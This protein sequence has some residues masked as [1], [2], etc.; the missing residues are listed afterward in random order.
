MR[1]RHNKAPAEPARVRLRLMKAVDQQAI[2]H[3]GAHMDSAG[4]FR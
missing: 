3:R 4:P 1:V 2:R